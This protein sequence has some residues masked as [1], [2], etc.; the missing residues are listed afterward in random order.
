MSTL[1]QALQQAREAGLERIDAQLLLLHALGRP[2]AGRAWLLTHDTDMLPPAQ[3]Q[4]FDALCARR[5]AG[6]P[7]AYLTGR[8]EFY[9][10]ALQVDARV[11]D[12]RPDTETLVDWALEVLADRPAPRIADLGTGSGA[13]ALAL[14]HQRP[15]AEVWAV[16]ASA[17]ALA[18]AEAN[19]RQ[20]GLAV[21]FA[22]GSWLQA[23]APG[24]VFDAIVTNPPYIAA[25]DPHLLSL[26]H[27]PLSA[28]ASG[29]DGLDDIRAIIDQAPVHLAPGGWLL[30]EHGWDQAPAV[31]ELLARAGFAQV[32]S[33]NDLAGIARCTGGCMMES[34]RQ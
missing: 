2:D 18:V 32:Q 3:Q 21:Q 26:T 17:D 15:D 10:L 19:A 29:S 9:G 34:R 31:Q 25:D 23:V 20:L 33:R 4:A 5:L 12:P 16:D 24:Q 30:I 8:K 27:E 11:L 14:Q 6:E 13:I 28:L 22:Q 1:Q 7:V